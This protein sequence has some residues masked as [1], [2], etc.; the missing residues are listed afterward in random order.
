MEAV[1]VE[2]VGKVALIRLNRPKTRNAM[3][4]E[5]KAGLSSAFPALMSDHSVRCVVL[6]GSE[7]AFCAGGDLTNMQDRRAPAVRERLQAAHAWTQLL[8]TGETPVIG[9]VNG[10]AAGAG[11]ALAM[12]C[13]VLLMSETAY[14]QAGFPAIGAVPDLGLALTLPRAVGVARAREI[15]LTNRRIAAAEAVALGI[16]ARA[17]TPDRLMEDVMAMAAGIA[18]GPRL[19]TGLTKQLLNQAYGPIE[20]FMQEEAMAQAVAF[21]GDEFPEGVDAFLNKRKPNFGG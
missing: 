9:A 1:T 19:S 14:F 11:F 2:R 7:N 5:I 16:A 4:V 15:L 13:D 8:L 20:R 21:G 12:L 10:A 6:T 17:V 18:A 3:S